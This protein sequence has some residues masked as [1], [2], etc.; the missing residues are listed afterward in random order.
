MD[1]TDTTGIELSESEARK[2]INALSEYETRATGRE[3]ERALNVERLLQREF[4]FEEG[5][6][7]GGD[8]RDISDVFSN[9][10]DSD[11]GTHEIQLSRAEAVE[12]VRA[13]DEFD[14]QESPGET[15]TVTN[16][17]DRFVRA[18]DVDDVDEDRTLGR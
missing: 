3:G 8:D 17:R 13:L 6:V 9:I 14:G 18:F 7:G 16:V 1:D 10:F 12:V 4:G 15:E 11:G 5:Q 2:V